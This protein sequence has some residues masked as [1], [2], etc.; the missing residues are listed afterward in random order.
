LIAEN[1]G[2]FAKDREGVRERKQRDF[3]ISGGNVER[4]V[5]WMPTERKML[6]L[7]GRKEAEKRS[8]QR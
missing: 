6:S 2:G 4:E 5:K 3:G 8:M 1:G 7:F